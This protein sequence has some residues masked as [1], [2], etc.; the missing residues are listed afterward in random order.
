MYSLIW[1]LITPSLLSPLPLQ[2]GERI[3]VRGFGV[4]NGIKRKPSP[5]ASPLQR[6]RRPTRL[7]TS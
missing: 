6:A 7:P 3:K 1:K 4:P 2:E 5:S